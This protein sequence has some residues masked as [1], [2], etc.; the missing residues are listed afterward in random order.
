MQYQAPLSDNRLDSAVSRGGSLLGLLVVLPIVAIPFEEEFQIS[1][2]SLGKLSVLPLLTAVM[3]FRSSRWLAVLKSPVSIA[4]FGFVAWAGITEVFRLSPSWDFHY[5]VLQTIV[6]ATLVA[7]TLSSR[8]NF[9]QTL[10]PLAL[11]CSGLGVYLLLNFYSKVNVHVTGFREASHARSEAFMGMGVSANLNVLA[12]TTG[13]GAAVA[14]ARLLSTRT[15][16]GRMLWGSL[17]VLCAVGA[18]VPLSRGALFAVVASS[19]IVL[20]RSFRKRITLRKILPVAAVVMLLVFFLPGAMI[21]RLSLLGH[22]AEMSKEDSRFRLYSK[23]L[24]L[25]PKFWGLGVGAGNYWQ[26]WA[27]ENGLTKATLLGPSPIG[28]HNG[29]IAAWMYFG[30][31]GVALLCLICYLTY[32]HRPRRN[33]DSWESLAIV[34]LLMFGGIWLFFTHN[35]YLKEFGLILGLLIGAS[36]RTSRPGKMRVMRHRYPARPLRVSGAPVPIRDSFHPGQGP[37]RR[38]PISRG[39]ANISV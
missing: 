38:S 28:P 12:F 26:S 6:F 18:F 8:K 34:G 25:F 9:S 39:L 5:R 13:I 17:Y 24:D 37:I 35:L 31:P 22:T 10:V 3:M 36:T 14:L 32:R 27:S 29:F 23:G 4:A 30:I 21:Q 16:R 11:V 33:D 7:A 1:D 19:A 15:A 2:W 20:L